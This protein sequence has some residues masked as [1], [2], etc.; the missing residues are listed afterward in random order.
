MNR[1]LRSLIWVLGSVGAV[2]A[3]SG[4]SSG[5]GAA[6]GATDATVPTSPTER[7][8]GGAARPPCTTND[9]C[10]SGSC[11]NQRCD[12]PPGATGD[13]SAPPPKP[14]GV[15]HGTTCELDRACASDA[16]CASNLCGTAGPSTGKCI[17]AKSC[18]GG[19]GANTKCNGGKDDCCASIA[20]PG[21]SFTNYDPY[22]ASAATV[23]PFKLD[24]FEVTV[25][26]LRAYYTSIGGN[27]RGN[28]PAPGAGAHPLIPDSGWRESWNVRLPG[29]WKEINA[30]HAA[31]CA[32]GGYNPQ[33]GAATWTPEP[34]PNEEKPINCIDWY[35]LFA[36]AVWDGGRLATDAEWSFVAYSGSEQRT[37]PWG[38]DVAAFDTHKDVLTTSFLVPGMN[39]GRYTAGPE[40]RTVDEGPAHISHVGTKT[41]RS[42]WGH[43]DLAGN[44][45]EYVLDV[46][47]SL[48]SSC[49]DCAN[50]AFPDPPQGPP[51]QPLRWQPLDANGKPPPGDGPDDFNDAKAVQDG[52]RFA[53]GGSW[54]G[55][56]EGHFLAN[57]KNRFWAPLW[58]TYG[59]LGG[60]VARDL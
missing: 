50:V 54:M 34:G 41:E 38:N 32:V 55:E 53:R 1:Q 5:N 58:R 17:S 29:S 36:F 40:Y 45:L 25:G 6:G 35:S 8:D 14:C 47:G 26:R 51:V 39:F 44:V 22:V 20:V 27:P 19:P 13:A 60:R 48:P 12:A 7:G 37:F 46:A 15:A 43:A 49:V 59:A 21:G 31:E 3:C 9:E 4:G 42:K 24:K 56:Y 57:T 16:D 10:A 33:W 11:S 28:P 30:R 18:T 2:A 52:K 23:A